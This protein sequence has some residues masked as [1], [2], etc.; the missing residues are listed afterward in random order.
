MKEEE[1]KQIDFK[2]GRNTRIEQRDLPKPKICY[3][4][5]TSLHEMWERESDDRWSNDGSGRLACTC[6]SLSPIS[7]AY[8]MKK[9]ERRVNFWRLLEKIERDRDKRCNIRGEKDYKRRKI[10][11]G[12]P[13]KT[14][15]FLKQNAWW[16]RVS[17]TEGESLHP[18]W[19]VPTLP[20]WD[21]AG[22]VWTQLFLRFW[23]SRLLVVCLVRVTFFMAGSG[24]TT[25]KFVS[26]QSFWLLDSSTKA[27]AQSYFRDSGAGFFG[28]RIPRFFFCSYNYYYCY[29]Y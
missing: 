3:K 29:Y 19:P 26:S 14:C 23:T 12:G 7:P 21:G 25:M 10:F 6:E 17:F 9:R 8:Q 18:C 5:I 27:A 1:D 2:E 15:L 13:K 22:D 16:T 28:N 4:T 11:R 20:H 24:W